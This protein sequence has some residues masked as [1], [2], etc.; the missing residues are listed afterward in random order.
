V[1]YLTGSGAKRACAVTS[2]SSRVGGVFI[3][4]KVSIHWFLLCVW[5][6]SLIIE[7]HPVIS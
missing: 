2:A 3:V 7:E 1:W 5:F 4:S 6:M